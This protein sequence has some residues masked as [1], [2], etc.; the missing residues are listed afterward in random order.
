MAVS[1]EELGELTVAF[2]NLISDVMII[3][4]PSARLTM[5][6]AFLKM[7]E[8]EVLFLVSLNMEGD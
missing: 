5:A 2:N 8:S 1:K 3:V 7:A 6:L 4:P